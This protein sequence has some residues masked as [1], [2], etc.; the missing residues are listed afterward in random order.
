M[1]KHLF[2]S[3]FIL[4]AAVLLACGAAR[5][6]EPC[7]PCNG[8][9]E[10]CGRPFDQVAFACTHNG[11]S[12]REAGYFFPNQD[13]RMRRQLEDG[14][15]AVMLDVHVED[16]R[17]MLCHG[18]CRLGSQTLVEGLVEIRE[19]LDAHPREVVALLVEGSV[20]DP[21]HLARDFRES[22]MLD[23]CHAQRLGD[24]W[25]TLGE[26][27]AANRRV[28]VLYDRNCGDQDW[29]LPMWKHMW[30][31]PWYPGSLEEFDCRLDRG[32]KTNALLNLNHFLKSQPTPRRHLA[33]AANSNPFFMDRVM[34][35]VRE[36][37]RIPN[38]I[39]VD[40]YEQGDVFSVVEAVNR[41]KK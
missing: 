31:T 38:F 23:L 2:P 6:D 35:C 30:D 17:L 9:P 18:F 41:L 39:T 14:I 34:K 27:I 15:R 32:E 25:P 33:L 3:R 1:S 16:G 19:F 24:P 36:I 12:S 20:P 29:L 11:M 10:L 40:F 8:M 26:M 7:E 5:P 13:R 21:E 37:G 28:V 22:G 4:T